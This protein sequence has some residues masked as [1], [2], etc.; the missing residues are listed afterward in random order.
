MEQVANKV[1]ALWPDNKILSQSLKRRQRRWMNGEVNTWQTSTLAA[2]FCMN[3]S[4]KVWQSFE[5]SLTSVVSGT[6]R[7]CHTVIWWQMWLQL[8]RVV[9]TYEACNLCCSVLSLA[10]LQSPDEQHWCPVERPSSNVVAKVRWAGMYIFTVD[11]LTRSNGRSVTPYPIKRTHTH[12]S[13]HSHR[14]AHTSWILPAYIGDP[15][16]PHNSIA[17]SSLMCQIS[18]RLDAMKTREKLVQ[19][20]QCWRDKIYTTSLR[21]SGTCICWLEIAAKMKLCIGRLST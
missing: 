3:S 9:L 6:C 19:P 16:R 17:Q 8:T 21:V 5:K 13:T 12:R 15:F 7:S 20:W 18:E 1:T 2:A 14:C 11:I 10:I 4:E